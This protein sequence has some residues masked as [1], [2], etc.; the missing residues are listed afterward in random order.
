L[1]IQRKNGDLGLTATIKFIF[2]IKQHPHQ[3]QANGATELHSVLQERLMV[4]EY[5]SSGGFAESF[6]ISVI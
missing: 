5:H 2:A 4:L 1:K 6:K 3:T